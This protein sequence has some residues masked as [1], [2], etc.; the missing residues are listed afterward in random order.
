MPSV[1]AEVASEPGDP[2]LFDL[3]LELLLEAIFRRYQH[4]FRGYAVASLRRRVRQAMERFDCPSV[5]ALQARVLHEPQVFAQLL[6]YFTVQVSEMFRDPAFFAAIRST[7]LPELATYPSLKI[8]IAGCSSGEEA[9][10]YAIMLAEEGL[11]ERTLI[12]GTD[13][14]RDALRQARAGVY[15]AGRVAEF[16][17][18]YLAAGGR[19]SLADYYHAAQGRVAFDRRFA[20]QLVFADHSLATDAVFSEVHLVSCRNVL[21]YFN[22]ALQDR[23]VDLFADALVDRGFLGL[24]AR[25]SLRFTAAAAR[26]DTLDASAQLY[27]RCPRAVV[28]PTTPDDA[29]AP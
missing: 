18:S 9:W 4:D 6:Q 19:G 2:A 5:S 26:F 15:D 8:W 1:D 25:E 13:I 16:S 21:I 23:A 22:R 3:E 12:Y 10:S 7:V 11:L 27:R 14:N 20:R 28:S 29:V 24:G 17:A